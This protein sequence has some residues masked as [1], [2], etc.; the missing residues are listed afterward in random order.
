MGP[1]IR[2]VVDY[3]IGTIQKNASDSPKH[4]YYIQVT[5]DKPRMTSRVATYFL[6]FTANQRT[7]EIAKHTAQI[8]KM[9]DLSAAALT[10]SPILPEATN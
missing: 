4:F 8:A 9:I 10:I 1:K 7:P 6:S 2:M 5:S 3:Y